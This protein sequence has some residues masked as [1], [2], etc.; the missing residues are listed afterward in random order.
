[1]VHMVVEDFVLLIVL[2]VSL[3]QKTEKKL[4]KRLVKITIEEIL[5]EELY[6]HK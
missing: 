6:V 4:I 5:K 2:G 3:H 1:M